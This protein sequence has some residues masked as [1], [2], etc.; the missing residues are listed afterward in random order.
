MKSL[1]FG[2]ITDLSGDAPYSEALKARDTDPILTPAFDSQEDI[3][4][5][6]LSDLQQAARLFE[7]GTG[8]GNPGQ[9]DL[10]FGGNSTRWYQFANSL[11]LRFAT[12]R[13]E[14]LPVPSRELISGVYNSSVYLR[15]ASED[16]SIAFNEADPWHAAAIGTDPTDFRRRKFGNRSG[17]YLWLPHARDQP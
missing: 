6:I 2:H 5:G 7:S 1:I 16:V 14:N 11:I 3:Y 10:Y 8:L 15:V 4:R 17:Q 9:A 13:S 12:R